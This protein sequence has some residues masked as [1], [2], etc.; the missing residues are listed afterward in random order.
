MHFISSQSNIWY[1]ITAQSTNR[2]V[3]WR[4]GYHFRQTRR[5]S[6]VQAWQHQGRLWTNWCFYL[7]QFKNKHFISGQSSVWYEIIARSTNRKV[8]WWN[9]YHFFLTGRGLQFKP[10]QHQGKLLTKWCFY[11]IKFKIMY[12]ISGQSKIWYEIT[13]S[14]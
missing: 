9:S 2:K 11:L 8:L 10:G 13:A 7:I 12:F 14:K 4:S 6:P 5:S 1:E 3:L